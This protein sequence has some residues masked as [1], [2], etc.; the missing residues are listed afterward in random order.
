MIL[1]AM[2]CIT[3]A[4]PAQASL[5]GSTVRGTLSSACCGQLFTQ[6]RV[7]GDVTEFA[8]IGSSDA[9]LQA[10]IHEDRISLVL[11]TVGSIAIGSDVEWT[12][13]ILTP[14]VEFAAITETFDGFLNGASLLGFTAT[15]ASFRIS[16]QQHP[17][18]ETYVA[19]Y[20]YTVRNANAVPEPA[21]LA[22]LGFAVGGLALARRRR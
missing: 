20:A 19:N 21:S 11:L 9:Q 16:N 17:F 1:G 12:F 5:F 13:E 6:D 14:G 22:L 4:L 2:A 15:T 18:D 8:F 10:D 7:V 3:L